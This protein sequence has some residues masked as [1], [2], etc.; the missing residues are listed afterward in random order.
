MYR[1]TRWKMEARETRTQVLHKKK[2]ENGGDYGEDYGKDLEWTRS[3]LCEAFY[4]GLEL[5]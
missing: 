5:G 1:F 2:R 4:G 3:T